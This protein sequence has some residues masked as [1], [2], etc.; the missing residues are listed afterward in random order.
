M[1]S[2]SI[3][4]A[5][6]EVHEEVI[7][8]KFDREFKQLIDERINLLRD[9]GKAINDD[10]HVEFSMNM[11]KLFKAIASNYEADIEGERS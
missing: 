6:I 7:R 5:A 4:S 8:E 10:F 1:I 11:V 2:K 9:C 3:L